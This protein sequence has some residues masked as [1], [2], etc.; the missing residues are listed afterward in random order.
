MKTQAYRFLPALPA[1]LALLLVGCAQFGLAPPA[2][3]TDRLAYA[4][5]THTAVLQATTA[6]LEVRDIGVEDAQRVLTIADQ[7]RDALDAAC[8]AIDVGDVSTA[9]G[10]LQLATA[11][12]TE[13]QS[14]L[15]R[16]S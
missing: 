16:Q 7:A 4:Y 15:R 11:I 3:L 6:A 12:L 10:R 9:E 8:L 5:G 13:L 2:S 14:Y 1:L